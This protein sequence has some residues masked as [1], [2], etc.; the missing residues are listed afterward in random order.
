MP[1]ARVIL[2]REEDGSCPFFDWMSKLPPKVQAKCLS[3]LERLREMGHELRR[4]EADYLRDGIYELR[5]TMQG[6]NHRILYFFSGN[7]AA[8]I[9][10]GFAKERMVPPRDIDRAIERMRRFE[11]SPKK[12]TLED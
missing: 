10:H 9:S 5:A 2:F 4:P 7:I 11:M 6:V 3:R 1:K 12:H 8:V